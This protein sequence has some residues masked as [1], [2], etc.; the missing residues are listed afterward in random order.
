[1]VAGDNDSDDFQPPSDDSEPDAEE[2]PTQRREVPTQ[3]RRRSAAARS[4]SGTAQVLTDDE[5]HSSHSRFFKGKHLEKR[6]DMAREGNP[7]KM[8][9]FGINR[10]FAS[11]D[12]FQTVFDEYSKKHGFG[13]RVRTSTTSKS[14]NEALDFN[15]CRGYVVVHAILC[16]LFRV[17]I[18]DVACSPGI[19]KK[20]THID[21]KVPEEEFSHVVKYIYCKH[22]CFDG[23]RGKGK[24][25]HIHYNF[26]GCQAEVKVALTQK[27]QKFV[28]RVIHEV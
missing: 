21:V 1:M 6:K 23:S 15:R 10:E 7:V 18:P 5:L 26:T 25:Q 14:N 16:V 4:S 27:G 11:W 24:R 13:W 28:I 8:P 9:P 20:N 2:V 19:R 12:G 22:K 3:R 17:F